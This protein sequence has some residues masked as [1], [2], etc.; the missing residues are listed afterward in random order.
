[1]NLG[2]EL[3]PGL[4]VYGLWLLSSLILPSGSVKYQLGGRTK[5]LSRLF[6]GFSTVLSRYRLSQILGGVFNVVVRD[7]K[8]LG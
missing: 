1:M 4:E 7:Y 6:G 2:G 3:Y 5:R 8:S